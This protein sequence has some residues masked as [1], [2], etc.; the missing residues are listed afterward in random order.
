M[1]TLEEVRALGSCLNTTW[2]KSSSNLK[3]THTLEGDRL[4]LKLQTIVHFDGSRSLNPQVVRERE[5]ANS[6]FKDALSKV[7][8]DF[9]ESVGRALTVKEVSRDDD[10]EIIQATSVSP[11]KVAY[12]RCQLRL[13]VS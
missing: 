6:I 2:G 12:Y 3:V 11:R 9:K 13:Q 4:D 7:K 5:I 10:V 8:A 1:L